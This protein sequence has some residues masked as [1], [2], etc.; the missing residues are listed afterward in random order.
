M[1]VFI[2][3]QRKENSYGAIEPNRH[4]WIWGNE[5]PATLLAIIAWNNRDIDRCEGM[6][7]Q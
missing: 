5:T 4:Q 6:E 7:Q 1:H 3:F 2:R